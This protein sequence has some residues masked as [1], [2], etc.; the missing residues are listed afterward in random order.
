[1]D[2]SDEALVIR[3]N[4][5]RQLLENPLLQAAFK[6]VRDELM[7]KMLSVDPLNERAHTRLIDGL[8]VAVMM[9]SKIKAHIQTGEMAA[10]NIEKL[11]RMREVKIPAL[12]SFRY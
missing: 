9:E 12:G 1:M 11:K 2:R 4:D 7:Q 6:A 8:K 5:A 3:G 10:W